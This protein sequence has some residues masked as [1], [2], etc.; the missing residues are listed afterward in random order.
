MA[1]KSP[2]VLVRRDA[3]EGLA[4]RESA[5]PAH[6][7]RHPISAFPVG[8]LLASKWRG[9]GIG[10]GVVMRTVVGRIHHDGVVGDTQF[11]Q[12]LEQGTNHRIVLHH[13]VGVLV[14][15][16]VAPVLRPH[17][18]AEMH[19]RGVPPN[20]EGHACL[21][22]P[23]DEVQRRLRGLLVHGL[24]ALLGQRASVLDLLCPVRIRP[25]VQDTARAELLPEFG[26]LR[27]VQVLRFFLG[28]QVVEVAE[29]LV[30]AVHRRQ[31]LV[32]VALVVLAELPGG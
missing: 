14:L 16:R 21:L 26:V 27:V 19:A 1:A 4:G 17:M 6:E 15:P 18:G 25:G 24:H 30:E 9:A 22:L 29:E 2:P 3:V 7:S 11:V 28:I 13:A 8:V 23:V 12:L 31:V 20:E 10:P 5:G 32:T